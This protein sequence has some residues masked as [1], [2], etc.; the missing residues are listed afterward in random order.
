MCKLL[1][2]SKQEQMCTA[3]LGSSA[4]VVADA[5]E[6]YYRQGAEGLVLQGLQACL[7]EL[8]GLPAPSLPGAACTAATALHCLSGDALC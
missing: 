6:M 1:H 3:V 2:D 5:K 4:L 7:G 8:P